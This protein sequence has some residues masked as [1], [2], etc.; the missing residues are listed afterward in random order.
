MSNNF[1]GNSDITKIFVVEPTNTVSF[2]A[3]TINI[4]G[5]ATIGGDIINCGSGSTLYTENIVACESGVTINNAITV[6]TTEVLPTSD[7]L[8]SVGSPSRRFRNI[9]TVSGTSTV[10]TATGIIYTPILNLGQDLSGN[11]REITAEN[12]II[13]DDILNG[14]S[15]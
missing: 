7:N 6:Y 8:I 3:E 11:T 13:Q 2:S 5:D 10:W 15:Y 4:T 1:C 9:N 14:G 12:S